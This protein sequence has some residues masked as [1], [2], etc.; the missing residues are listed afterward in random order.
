MTP[1]LRP[2]TGPTGGGDG[3]V[4]SETYEV[5]EDTSSKWFIAP[6]NRPEELWAI[7]ISCKKDW[8]SKVRSDVKKIIETQR[9]YTHVKFFTNQP[10][11]SKQRFDCEASLLKEFG[12][13]VKIFDASWLKQSVFDNDNINVAVDELNLS[14]QYKKKVLKQGA[15]DCKRTEQLNEIENEIQIYGHI[16]GTDCEYI[17]LLREAARL[18]RELE[19]P[20][21]E[22]KGRYRRAI[23]ECKRYG[24]NPQLY[25]LTYDFA[26]TAFFWLYDID[27]TLELFQDLTEMI[28]KHVNPH[29]VELYCNIFTLISNAN[30]AGLITD[31][32]II[33]SQENFNT[34]R[35]KVEGLNFKSCVLYLDMYQKHRE[36]LQILIDHHSDEDSDITDALLKDP[37]SELGSMI[38]ESRDHIDLSFEQQVDVI[39][40]MCK[41]IGYSEPFETLLDELSLCLEDRNK[42]IAA[43][44]I[45][46]ER[47]DKLFKLGKPKDAIKHLGFCIL[48]YAKENHIRE[49]ILSNTM[50]G[51]AL[52]DCGFPISAESFLI[53]AVGMQ[54]KDF[55]NHGQ[56]KDGLLVNLLKLCEIELSLGRIVMFLNWYELLNIIIGTSAHETTEKFQERNNIIDIG[57]CCQFLKAFDNNEDLVNLPDLLNRNYLYTTAEILKYVLGYKDDVSP[58]LLDGILKHEDWK[59]KLYSLPINNQFYSDLIV[60]KEGLTSINVN[61]S[62]CSI[63]AIYENSIFNQMLAQQMIS[64]IELI[65]ATSDEESFITFDGSIVIE[66]RNIEKDETNVWASED[67]NSL[68]IIEANPKE[69]SPDVAW[70]CIAEVI[71]IFLAKSSLWKRDVRDIISEK[72]AKE[73]IM[74]RLSSLLLEQPNIYEIL[75]NDFKYTIDCW[76]KSDDKL[77][78]STNRDVSLKTIDNFTENKKNSIHLKRLHVSTSIEWWDK[79]KWGGVGFYSF[80]NRPPILTLAFENLNYGEKIFKEWKQLYEN[81]SF[82]IKI[83]FITGFD[84]Y[85][86]QWYR[87]SI[88]PDICSIRQNG[89][90]EGKS[91]S[92]SRSSTMMASSLDNQYRFRYE[93]MMYRGCWLM[94]SEKKISSD[95]TD[96]KHLAIPFFNIEFRE[97]W[98]IGMNEQAIVGIRPGDEPII[99]V[100]HT[101]DAPILEVLKWF[102]E[103]TGD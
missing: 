39:K 5:S 71:G 45:H 68:I 47:A 69:Y 94:P 22:T 3:K 34:L 95:I 87:V 36:I 27:L 54:I 65:I 14:E 29:R 63:S 26:W 59:E 43:A 76:Q 72:Q 18:S 57:W 24:T 53:K 82:N 103:K 85:N 42:D 15:S 35:E 62:S 81:K 100:N 50:M 32:I 23:N 21:E 4:D 60:S 78:Q 92:F 17:E 73:N 90:T 7:A 38:K 16:E 10:V 1:N 56:I 2:Q 49:F 88:V 91:Y 31:S 77:Y 20:K 67:S 98:A 102:Q 19:R 89:K 86:P 48:K 84:K 79:A 64:A 8:K 52:N 37:L 58:T 61:L 30:L 74:D 41:H 44:D 80:D 6:G 51:Y 75:G 13:D 28:N 11:P 66:V 97:A 93:Y 33:K 55:F 46:F 40:M 9:G 99:P 12:I 96:Y 101:H 25:Q 83:Y 70:K